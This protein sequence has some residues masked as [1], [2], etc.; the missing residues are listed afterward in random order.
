MNA[1]NG[2]LRI[3]GKEHRLRGGRR[4]IERFED[5]VDLAPALVVVVEESVQ[6]RHHPSTGAHHDATNVIV[7]GRLIG[8]E[9]AVIVESTVGDDHLEVGVQLQG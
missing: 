7:V 2:A 6:L 1:D 4:R 5:A 8:H 9:D 3:A